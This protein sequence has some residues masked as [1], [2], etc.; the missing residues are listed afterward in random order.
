MDFTAVTL[1][2]E[3]PRLM[4]VVVE[5]P[6]GEERRLA[7]DPLRGVFVPTGQRSLAHVRGFTGA[8]GWIGGLGTPP[9]RH[10]DALLLTRRRCAPGD[11]VPAT[12]AGL[13]RRTDGD[14]KVLGVDVALPISPAAAF[15]TEEVRCLYPD[16]EP[17]EGWE[18]ET[19]AR[20]YL[21]DLRAQWIPG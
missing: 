17:G 16:V 13:F 21:A 11:V 12:V 3:F 9:G 2:A 19:A 14:H 20:A 1:H 7:F 8:Y 5:Q 18:D 6:P 10:A 15:A 4:W